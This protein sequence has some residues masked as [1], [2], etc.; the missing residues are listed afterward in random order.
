[1]TGWRKSEGATSPRLT[2]RVTTHRRREARG[3]VIDQPRR[4]YVC[5]VLDVQRYV[6]AR[7]RRALAPT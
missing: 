7:F 2:E 1:M 5:A 4:G 6:T 3:G